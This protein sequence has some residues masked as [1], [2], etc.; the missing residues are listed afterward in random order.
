M[1]RYHHDFDNL[2]QYTA[3]WHDGPIMFCI[4]DE[5]GEY[6]LG[7]EENSEISKDNLLCTTSYNFVHTNLEQLKLFLFG[8]LGLQEMF[9]ST[10]IIVK[11][12]KCH[13]TQEGQL[14]NAKPFKFNSLA[15]TYQEFKITYPNEIG[16]TNILQDYSKYAHNTANQ[17]ILEEERNFLSKEIPIGVDYIIKKI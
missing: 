14:Q 17:W 13:V 10:D 12:I 8:W 5:Q 15:Y 6:W 16:D 9:E 3:V 4:K 2:I 1:Y 11:T 7:I